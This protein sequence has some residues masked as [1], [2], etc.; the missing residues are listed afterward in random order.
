MNDPS[1]KV[2]DSIHQL[3]ERVLSLEHRV[4]GHAD[5]ILILHKRTDDNTAILN[6]IQSTLSKLLYI[7]V[8][9]C[10]YHVASTIGFFD[11]LKLVVL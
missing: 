5:S 8:G 4:Q 9:L 3:S 10:L 11:A 1:G 2:M 6:K 7:S